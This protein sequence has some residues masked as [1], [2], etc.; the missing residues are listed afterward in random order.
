MRFVDLVVA[1]R[2]IIANHACHFHVASVFIVLA[3]V[4]A[5]CHFAVF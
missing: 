5:F 4:R 3:R 2:I 1:I